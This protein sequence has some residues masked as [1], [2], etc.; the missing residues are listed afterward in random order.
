MIVAHFPSGCEKVR[1]LDKRELPK[2]LHV[3]RDLHGDVVP[4]AR[5]EGEQRDGEQRDAVLI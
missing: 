5:A 1:H 3:A 2:A 4:D